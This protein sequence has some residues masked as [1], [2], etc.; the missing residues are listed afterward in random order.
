[1]SAAPKRMAIVAGYLLMG[2]VRAIVIVVVSVV[3]VATG[4]E[5]K[6]GPLDM[7]LSYRWRCC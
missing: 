3:V 7:P 2:V 1:M 4:M 6:G 5:V